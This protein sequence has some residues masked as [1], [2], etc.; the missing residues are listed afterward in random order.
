MPYV[1]KAAATTRASNTTLSDDPDIILPLTAQK[2]YRIYGC[3]RWWSG[4]TPDFK[5]R[6]NFTGTII[7]VVGSMGGNDR[8]VQT[9]SF[10][11]ANTVSFNRNNQVGKGWLTDGTSVI[12]D[13]GIATNTFE[14]TID[15]ECYLKVG[16]TGG[17]FS[18]QWA[19]TTSDPGLTR[20]SAQSFLVVLEQR[21]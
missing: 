16:D 17:D 20:V 3:V 2:L 6:W 11:G 14:A 18:F 13:I 9:S 21:G 8:P 7:W 5:W 1:V 4:T 19:Q 10:T 15:I 12:T